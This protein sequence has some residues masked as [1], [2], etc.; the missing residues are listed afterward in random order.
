[1]KQFLRKK[2]FLDDAN[3]VALLMKVAIPIRMINLHG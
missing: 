2:L 3:N 1:M